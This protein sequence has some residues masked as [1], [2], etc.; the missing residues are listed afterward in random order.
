MLHLIALVL[1]GAGVYA[2]YRWL[3]REFRRAVGTVGPQAHA[4]TAAAQVAG[5]PK[6]LGKLEW[7]E[8][9]GV[10]RPTRQV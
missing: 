5:V 2:G 10:Y 4:K 1:G 9:A 8:Q 7:D 3:S 6:D